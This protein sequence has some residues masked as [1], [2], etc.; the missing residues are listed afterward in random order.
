MGTSTKC[1]Q[2]ARSSSLTPALSVSPSQKTA[3]RSP[4]GP[5]AR[6]CRFPLTLRLTPHTQSISKS[7]RLYLQNAS[8]THSPLLVSTAHA[9]PRP[10]Q[11]F[12]WAPLLPLLPDSPFSTERE[13]ALLPPGCPGQAEQRGG[14][15]CGGSTVRCGGQWSGRLLSPRRET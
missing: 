15:L 10:P 8:R 14:G 9:S 4:P 1:V 3:G 11:S 7:C 13:L 12:W 6:I 2:N 5:Y